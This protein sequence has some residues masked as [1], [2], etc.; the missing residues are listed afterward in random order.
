MKK[1]LKSREQNPWTMTDN[2]I[3]AGVMIEK[4]IKSCQNQPFKEVVSHTFHQISTS[5]R[6]LASALTVTVR[7]SPVPTVAYATRA[8]S[9][10]WTAKVAAVS[11]GYLT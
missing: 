4:A 3:C 11:N 5:V 2:F 7:T 8:S 1:K 6:S 10:L 9:H